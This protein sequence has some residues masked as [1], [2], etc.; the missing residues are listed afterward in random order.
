MLAGAGKAESEAASLGLHYVSVEQRPA[1]RDG[2][3]MRRRRSRRWLRRLVAA[4]VAVLL[5]SVAATARLFIW[6]ADGMPATVNAIIMLDS[7]QGDTLGAALRLAHQH[8][9]PYL[10]ISLGTPLSDPYKCPAPMPRVKVVCFNPEPATTQG[11]AEFLG[12]LAHRFRWHSVAVVTM[13][14]QASRARL[15]VERCFSGQVYVVTAPIPLSAWPYQLAYQWG[16]LMKALV[17][18]R[19]C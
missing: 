12:R 8:R 4:V 17:V 2:V 16:A 6:P 14:P 9:A 13:T 15:R 18:Q 7:P 1:A 5:V 11:E 3:G 10:L 19:S